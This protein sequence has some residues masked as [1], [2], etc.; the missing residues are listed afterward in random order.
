MKRAEYTMNL[1]TTTDDDELNLAKPISIR[2]L[3]R[4]NGETE[5][6]GENK[7]E[8]AEP[9][10]SLPVDEQ[11][12]TEDGKQEIVGGS[13][14]EGYSVD[15]PPLADRDD[16]NENPAR[17]ADTVSENEDEGT[18]SQSTENEDSSDKTEEEG[19]EVTPQE[20]EDGNA[21]EQTSDDQSNHDEV[22]PQGEEEKRAEEQTLEENDEKQTKDESQQ[23]EEEDGNA[24]TQTLDDQS[25]QDKVTPQEEDKEP[26]NQETE[27]SQGHKPHDDGPQLPPPDGDETTKPSSLHADTIPRATQKQDVKPH[28]QHLEPPKTPEIEHNQK[29]QS[30]P[31]QIQSPP[32][33]RQEPPKSNVGHVTQ[34]SHSNPPP[35][36]RRLPRKPPATFSPMDPNA[37]KACC[38]RPTLDQGPDLFQLQNYLD[39]TEPLV[40]N[41]TKC[42]F[43]GIKSLHPPEEHKPIPRETFNFFPRMK[44]ECAQEKSIPDGPPRGKNWPVLVR[45]ILTDH[46]MMLIDVLVSKKSGHWQEVRSLKK[47]VGDNLPSVFANI[48]TSPKIGEIT[49]LCEDADKRKYLVP[50]ERVVLDCEL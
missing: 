37:I 13:L 40:P 8:V 24:E 28:T 7:D 3:L 23:G 2:E 32:F 44:D 48:R 20:E 27:P 5:V 31:E 4:R 10:E 26:R 47:A 36:S 18:E 45:G 17:G 43:E 16:E 35:R 34:E 11:L 12:D 42:K 46:R 21:E 30:K 39:S 22:T 6:T 15:K 29:Q 33:T 25:S 19:D 49:C 50:G 14:D 41:T 38:C 1:L 9:I